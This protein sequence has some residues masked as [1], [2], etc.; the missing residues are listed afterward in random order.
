MPVLACPVAAVP[1]HEPTSL[2][3]PSESFRRWRASYNDAPAPSSISAIGPSLRDEFLPPAAD[4]PVTPM[5][6]SYFDFYTVN[7]LYGEY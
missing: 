7:H 2:A 1:C 6:C 4:A 3:Q 5:S